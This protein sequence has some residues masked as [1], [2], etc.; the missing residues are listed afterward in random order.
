MAK[1][2]ELSYL[3]LEMK[4]KQKQLL[5]TKSLGKKLMG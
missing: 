2:L 5:E 4:Q 3:K 1:L